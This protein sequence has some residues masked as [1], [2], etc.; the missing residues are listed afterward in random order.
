RGQFLASSG[1]LEDTGDPDGAG[2]DPR[3]QPGLLEALTVAVRCNHAKVISRDGD[4]FDVLGDPTEGA[5]LVAGMKAGLDAAGGLELLHEIPFDPERKM[6]SVVWK[7]RSGAAV[8]YAKG[9]P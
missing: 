1:P 5:L 8:L 7:E 4:R 9:A 2:L 3:D 6:M